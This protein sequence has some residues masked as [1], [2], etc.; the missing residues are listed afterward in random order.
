MATA[1]TTRSCL[2]ETDSILESSWADISDI[3]RHVGNGGTPFPDTLPAAFAC[4]FDYVTGLVCRCRVGNLRSVDA[5]LPGCDGF[6]YFIEFKDVSVNPIADLK[7]KAFD[8]LPVFWLSLGRKMSMREICAKAIFVYVKPNSESRLPV[9]DSIAESLFFVQDAPSLKPPKSLHGNSTLNLQLNEL[10]TDALYYDVIIETA[11]EFCE[12]YGNRFGRCSKSD[13]I[14]RLPL[15]ISSGGGDVREDHGGTDFTMS[16]N[17]ILIASRM[18]QGGVSREAFCSDDINAYDFGKKADRLLRKREYD[19]ENAAAQGR[20]TYYC[21][22]AFRR[23]NETVYAYHNWSV[24]YPIATVVN[25]AFDTFLLWAWICHPDMKIEALMHRLGFVV[26]C[27]G[28]CPKFVRH[29]TQKWLQQFYDVYASWF[30]GCYV[31]KRNLP[32]KY[33]LAC[34]R[35]GLEFYEDVSTLTVEDFRTVL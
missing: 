4:N 18:K 35:D 32:L 14:Q 31:D 3:A 7:K 17:R 27:D 21:A 33:G 23:E 2:A 13:F 19:H 20:G 15:G 22:D 12:K 8:S 30:N 34:Y 6:I 25:K 11:R 9:S 26:V 1:M 28:V 24:E 5:V 10:R 16:L 29:K